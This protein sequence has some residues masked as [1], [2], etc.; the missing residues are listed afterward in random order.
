[1][2]PNA[3]EAERRFPGPPAAQ[4]LR[5]ARASDRPRMIVGFGALR[6]VLGTGGLYPALTRGATPA[7]HWV[8][9]QCP[10]DGRG[11]PEG[12]SSSDAASRPDVRALTELWGR[13]PS[14]PQVRKILD[15]IAD[16]HGGPGPGWDWKR[17]EHRRCTAQQARS[18]RVSDA[19]G[20][21]QRSTSRDSASAPHVSSTVPMIEG[22]VMTETVQLGPACD[23]CRRRRL[24]S[25]HHQAAAKRTHFLRD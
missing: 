19:P 3:G 14:G 5:R 16:R 22:S 10:S 2:T 25:P 24:L 9:P 15:R 20:R 18:T 7:Q 23:L 11:R 21:G 4:R 12:P 13:P 17:L 6:A 1:M 8:G